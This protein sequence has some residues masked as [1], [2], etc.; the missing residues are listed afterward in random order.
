[1]KIIEGK[2]AVLQPYQTESD[3]KIR[4]PIAYIPQKISNIAMRKP[5]DCESQTLQDARKIIR[6]MDTL[7]PKDCIPQ[8]VSDAEMR[9]PVERPIQ[10]IPDVMVQSVT[11]SVSH[12]DDIVVKQLQTTEA[13]VIP[14]TPELEQMMG[15]TEAG[16]TR[17]KKKKWFADTIL[18]ITNSQ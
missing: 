4:R 15:E 18:H 8:M 6:H 16:R 14:A 5:I 13:Q 10:E 1:M 3:A 2:Q 17:M 7:V 9:K 12:I 11:E